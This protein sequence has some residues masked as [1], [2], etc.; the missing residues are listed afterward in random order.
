MPVTVFGDNPDDTVDLLSMLGPPP[1]VVKL[2]EG[3]QGRG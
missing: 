2:N 1:H 3:T